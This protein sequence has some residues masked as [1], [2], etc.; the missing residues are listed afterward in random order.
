MASVLTFRKGAYR[1]GSSQGIT[2]TGASQQSSA[3]SSDASIIRVAVNQDTYI[4]IGSNPTATANS[5]MMPAGAIEF[6]AVNAS[7]KVAVLEVS[8]A[9]RVSITELTAV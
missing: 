7:D 6:F 2:T 9:G 3:L 1:P 4:A 8:A 5:L